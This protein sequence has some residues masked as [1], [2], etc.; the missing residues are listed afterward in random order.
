MSG[1][2]RILWVLCIGLS[3]SFTMTPHHMVMAG[4]EREER[5]D[6]EGRE[7]RGK[8]KGREE[9]EGRE[10][11][12]RSRL[13]FIAIR[14]GNVTLMAHEQQQFRAFAHYRDGSSKDI[15][16]RARWFS[17]HWRVGRINK[18]GKFTANSAGQASIWAKWKN[19]WSEAASVTVIADAPET[20]SGNWTG[21]WT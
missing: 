8:R 17:N 21:T 10:K 9:R 20:L 11:R 6:R 19:K 18:K 2:R 4:E 3:L 7:K 14:P 5:E 12:K 1:V 15:T 16:K 13:S